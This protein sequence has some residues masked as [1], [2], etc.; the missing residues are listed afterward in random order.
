MR[1]FRCFVLA[2]L[3]PVLSAAPTAWAGDV[4]SAL[5]NGDEGDEAD[6]ARW[7]LGTGLHLSFY[8]APEVRGG[9]ERRL[10]PSTWL[11]LL[12]RGRRWTV[13]MTRPRSPRRVTTAIPVARSSHA[14]A[15]AS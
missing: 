12:V 13:G 9:G 1:S 2:V 3:A 10:S 15:C 6:S 11:G 5:P 14:V 7:T 8:G 4:P